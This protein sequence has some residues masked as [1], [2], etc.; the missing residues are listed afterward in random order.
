MKRAP[1]SP[2]D[3]SVVKKNVS[4]IHINAKLSLIQRKLVNALLYN[5]YDHLLSQDTHS[6]NV[7][8]LSEMIGFDSR[9]LSHLKVALAGLAKTEI[10]WD[11][12]EDN[13]SLIHISEPT[14]P[15]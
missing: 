4:V 15:Y 11:I 3:K 1:K 7:A 5:A 10:Q 14:R 8:L 2:L 6:L 9:N 12:L 13:L